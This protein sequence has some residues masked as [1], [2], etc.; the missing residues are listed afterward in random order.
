[1]VLQETINDAEKKLDEYEEE[2]RKDIQHEQAKRKEKKLKKKKFNKDVQKWKRMKNEAYKKHEHDEE[3]DDDIKFP[4]ITRKF[5][6]NDK[7]SKLPN[8]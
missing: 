8:P 7:Y 5:S 1:M 2:R 6:N 4:I 3:S